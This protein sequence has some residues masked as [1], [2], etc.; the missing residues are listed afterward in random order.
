MKKSRLLLFTMAF[1]AFS[2]VN[3]E[4]FAQNNLS[5]DV[6]NSVLNWK[7]HKPTGS[8]NGGIKLISG[9][10]V[11]ENNKLTGGNFVADMSTIKDADGSAKL[12]GHLKSE[13]FFE[14]E[15]Y[16]T[17]QFEI[18]ETAADGG[19]ILVT[20][21]MTIKGITKQITFPATLSV[22]NDSVTLTSETFQVNRT[23]FN[24]KY[25][26]KSFFND[27]KD[28]FLNDDFDFQVTI[29]AKK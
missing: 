2:F 14:I 18:T 19:G 25:K 7:G 1:A 22:N 5:V 12:E 8:H 11:I 3:P 17:S 23:D 6:E 13:D 27:L 20:G 10:V 15:V 9:D 29:V 28:K 26:S 16:P 24:V 21:N 4:L